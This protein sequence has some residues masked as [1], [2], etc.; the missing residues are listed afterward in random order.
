HG[1]SFDGLYADVKGDALF[2]DGKR[3]EAR[4]AYQIALEK[5]DAASPTRQIVQLKLDALG[6]SK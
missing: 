6:E 3:A 1:D 4:A 5:S 2:A